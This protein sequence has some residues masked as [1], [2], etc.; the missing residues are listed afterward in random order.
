MT[1]SVAPGSP[2]SE[3][4]APAMKTGT[5][6]P[7][8]LEELNGG[9]PFGPGPDQWRVHVEDRPATEIQPPGAHLCCS[10]CTQSITRLGTWSVTLESLKPQI[11]AHV[12]QVHPGHVT[13]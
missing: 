4:A 9:W 11:A 7:T 8:P 1:G 13:R 6:A 2:K 12:M 10:W 5:G 3:S